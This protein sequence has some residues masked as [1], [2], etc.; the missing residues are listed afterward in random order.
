[1]LAR[2]NVIAKL[3]LTSL[4]R[5]LYFEAIPMLLGLALTDLFLAYSHLLEFAPTAGKVPLG[6]ALRIGVFLCALASGAVASKLGS[7][8]SIRMLLFTCWLLAAT[9]FSTWRGGSVNLLTHFWFPSLLGFLAVT[10]LFETSEAVRQGIIAIGFASALIAM[11]SLVATKVDVMRVGIDSPTLSNPNDLAFALLIGVPPIVFF[12]RSN[13]GRRYLSRAILVASLVLAVRMVANTASRGGLLIICAY[14]LAV[15]FSVSILNKLKLAAVVLLLGIAFFTSASKAALLRYETIL[16]F[17]NI[18]PGDQ[19]GV[20][21]S[22]EDSMNQ[23]RDLL[24]ES[25]KLT[26]QNPVFGVG[27]GAYQSAAAAFS[28]QAGQRA[29]WH[30]SHNTYT[31][32]SSETGVPGF[33]LY[34]MVLIGSFTAANRVRR[35]TAGVSGLESVHQTAGCL[36]LMLTCFALNGF[37]AS[38]AYLP[39]FP[40]IAAL[41]GSLER[42]ATLEIAAL[43]Q[44]EAPFSEPSASTL[45]LRPL[46]H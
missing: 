28:H 1:M 33:I 40:F 39:L 22:A 42:S 29:N 13:R 14:A 20:E 45:D 15:F 5:L 19:Q 2:E 44:P 27:P 10:A 12:L 21:D 35:L 11:L 31:E 18:D 32:V 43:E 46:L 36:L 7:T 6:S 34:M 8:L 3:T 24:L 17:L 41:A 26:M 9:L 30:E 25:L 4:S 23:R 38:M 37:F 16:P